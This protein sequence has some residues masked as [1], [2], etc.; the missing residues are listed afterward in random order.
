MSKIP[1]QV[2][3]GEPLRIAASDWNEM[4]SL[5]SQ[6]RSWLSRAG[7]RATPSAPISILIRNTSGVE[8]PRFGILGLSDPL[9]DPADMEGLESFQE[10]PALDGVKPSESDRGMFCIVLEPLG[11]DAIGKGLLVGVTPVKIDVTDTHHKWADIKVDA[12]SELKSA[13]GGVC[14]ILWK[15]TGIGSKWAYVLKGLQPQT[16]RLVRATGSVSAGSSGLFQYISGPK[17]AETDT[18]EDPVL[19]YSPGDDFDEND[20]GLSAWIDTGLE[21]NRRTC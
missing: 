6:M 21:V 3:S 14:Q 17:G 11:N 20:L 7:N 19:M 4:R 18:D 12:V 13:T 15:Q 10:T 1:G 5:C 16:I 2:R 8:I 9:F